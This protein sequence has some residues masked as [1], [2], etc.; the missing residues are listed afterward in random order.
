MY[1]RR[2][3]L[4]NESY[5]NYEIALEWILHINL[6]LDLEWWKLL[7]LQWD[8]VR[9]TLFIWLPFQPT[10]DVKWAKRK[11]L[12]HVASFYDPLRLLS[13]TINVDQN[14]KVEYDLHIVTDATTTAYCAAAYLVQRCDDAVSASSLLMSKSRLT[15]LHQAI[16]IPRLE[17]AA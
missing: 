6:G 4:H 11:V 10:S 12:K 17:L 7:G 3:V 16:T 14:L 1:D 2:D 5:L 9:D 8:I 15:H 13:P